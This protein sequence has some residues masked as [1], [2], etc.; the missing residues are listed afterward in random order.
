MFQTAFVTSK[1]LDR[2]RRALLSTLALLEANSE[3]GQVR[4]LCGN[5]AFPIEANDMSAVQ[6]LAGETN[7]IG[8]ASLNIYNLRTLR[9]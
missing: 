9:T 6:M 7:F 2:D 3:L 8:G 4:K 5:G 1:R